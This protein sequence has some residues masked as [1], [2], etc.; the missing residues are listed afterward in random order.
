[1]FVV[2]RHL[3]RLPKLHALSLQGS[4]NNQKEGQGFVYAHICFF[5]MLML[6]L[7]VRCYHCI[8]Q[9]GVYFQKSAFEVTTC[10]PA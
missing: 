1:M 7:F 5:V 2:M 9:G 6:S 3:E 10:A 4:N 8:P